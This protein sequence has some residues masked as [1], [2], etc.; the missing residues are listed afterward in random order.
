MREVLDVIV[1]RA[2][3]DWQ[4][5]GLSVA[6]RFEGASLAR[7]FGVCSKAGGQQVDTESLFGLASCTKQFATV[8]ALMLQQDGLLALDDHVREHLPDFTLS[9]ETIAEKVTIRDLMCNR[10]GLLP[11]EGRHRQCASDRKD[12]IRRMRFQPFRH[13]FGQN[14]GYCTDAYTLLGEVLS[15]A[16]EKPWEQ[17]VKERIFIPLGMDNTNTS[18]K[19]SRETPNHAE[20]HLFDGNEYRPIKW[21]YEDD[22]AA[23][24]GGINSCAQD[25]ALWLEFLL[26]GKT[27]DGTVLLSPDALAVAR[28]PH[29]SDTGPYRDAELSQAMGSHKNLVSEEAYGLGWYSHIYKG[30]HIIYHT[31]SIDG[32]R[33]LTG[34]IPSVGFGVVILCNADNP[35]LPRMIFQSLT[36]SA[37]KD[38]SIDWSPVFLE[39]QNMYGWGK[40]LQRPQTVNLGPD[41]LKVYEGLVGT[42][43]DETGFGTASIYKSSNKLQMHIGSLRFDIVPVSDTCFEAHKIWPYSTGAQFVASIQ[44][45]SGGCVSAFHTSQSAKFVR[46][47]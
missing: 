18:C 42:Y 41:K 35:F 30:T 5:P 9:D 33:S 15:A 47:P 32:F 38:T 7:G 6:L 46:S 13:Q 23:P 21:L 37:L 26:S 36:D 16:S 34:L 17:L 20:P 1:E 44:Y 19:Q 10:L 11:S 14:Y 2:L 27:A 29:T 8:V 40:T 28:Q 43:R 3:K 39:Y 12:L 31:G 22:V 25:M 4:Q 24:A 45:A